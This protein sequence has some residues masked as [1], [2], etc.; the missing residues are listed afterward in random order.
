MRTRKSLLLSGGILAI[1]ALL[2]ATNAS[3]ATPP[4]SCTTADYRID[5]NI[6]TIGGTTSYEYSLSKLPGH[7]KSANRFFEFVPPGLLPSP[8]GTVAGSPSG[9]FLLNGSFT[10]YHCPPS[11]AWPYN[12]TDDG[13][14]F[15]LLAMG[16]KMKLSVTGSEVRTTTALV[17]NAKGVGEGEFQSCAIAG[18]GPLL[19]G[20]PL[21]THTENQT[22]ANG[23]KYIMTIDTNN[24]VVGAIRDPRGPDFAT[25]DPFE[26]CE[27]VVAENICETEKHLTFCPPIQGGEQPIQGELGGTCYYPKNIKVTC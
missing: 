7:T 14:C 1:V 23:C 5:V 27:V 15:S 11:S 21:A 4:I 24:F 22:M 25:V 6:Q 8:V 18:P 26:A 3:S 17:G 16:D 20:S 12:K 19:P 13:Y 2:G 9:H 10:P